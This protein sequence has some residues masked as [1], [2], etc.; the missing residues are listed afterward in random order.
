M[1][2]NFLQTLNRGLLLLQ[3]EEDRLY[4]KIIENLDQV[5]MHFLIYFK[6]LDEYRT[7]HRDIRERCNIDFLME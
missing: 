5:P 2:E 4:P 1:I 7:A 6:K 3:R